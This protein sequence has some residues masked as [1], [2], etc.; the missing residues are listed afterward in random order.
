LSTFPEEA[1]VSHPNVV[2][3]AERAIAAARG[4]A[5]AGPAERRLPIRRYLDPAELEWEREALFRRLPLVLAHAAE[6]PQAGAFLTR[7]VVGVPVLAARGTDGRARAFLNSCRHR[8]TRLTAEPCGARK[9]FTCP[10]HGWSYALDGRLIHLP[11]PEAFAGACSAE[12]GLVE[13]PLVEA[14]GL[15]WVVLQP[16]GAID[17][18]LGSIAEELDA[19]QLDRHVLFRS[20]VS[21]R[22]ANW[23]LIA[24]AFLDGY[25][26]RPL[27]RDSIYR[28]FIDGCFAA[29]R[30]GRHIRAATARRAALEDGAPLREQ[31]TP[32]FHLFPN[33][34][35][36]LHPD[37][38]SLLG[39]SPL[40]V[41]RFEWRHAMLL[42]HPP[43]SDAEEAHFQRSFELL[44]Q[45]VFGREDLFVVEEIQAG[46]AA[47]AQE[48]LLIGA[49]EQPILWFHDTIDALREAEPG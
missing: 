25:H 4:A 35:L 7:E 8:G 37:S 20:S 5:E 39:F 14:H 33:S 34:V 17:L 32:T 13:L 31:V 15:L 29:E 28:F 26:I 16:G 21:E 36:V 45:Q 49:L 22:R 23:K 42:P 30:V 47:R 18:E 48:Q 38:I 1:Q 44:D 9:A 10:Y 43:A 24:E 19:F 11:H 27:H 2:A 12:L 40:A 3:V 41:D 6:L 46:L